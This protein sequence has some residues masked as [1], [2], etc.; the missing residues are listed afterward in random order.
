VVLLRPQASPPGVKESAITEIAEFT[1]PLTSIEGR[2]T[3]YVCRNFSCE[4]PTTD[5][6]RMLELLSAGS[7]SKQTEP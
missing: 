7:R 5:V 6:E 3:A 1:M 4:L 2:A